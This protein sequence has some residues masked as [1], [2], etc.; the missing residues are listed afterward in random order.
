MSLQTWCA[1]NTPKPITLWIGP[2]GGWSREELTQ[3]ETVG[4][5][6][7]TFGARVLRT[8]SAAAA[9]AAALQALWTT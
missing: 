7:I 3:F 8:E 9:I 4:A 6:R 1:T 2:E 5:Q